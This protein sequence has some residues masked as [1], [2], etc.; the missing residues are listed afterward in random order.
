M[1]KAAPLFDRVMRYS[2]LTELQYYYAEFL[3][4]RQHRDEAREFAQRIGASGFLA[5][6]FDLED[7]LNAV[8]KFAPAPSGSQLAAVV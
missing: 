3:A 7:L 5:K 2:T 8:A 6:P 4:A 1:D